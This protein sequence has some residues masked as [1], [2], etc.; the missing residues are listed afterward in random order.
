MLLSK[1]DDINTGGGAPALHIPGIQSLPLTCANNKVRKA[2]GS[3]K[4][5]AHSGLACK[6]LAMTCVKLCGSAGC[7]SKV[8]SSCG[9]TKFGEE[10]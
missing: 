7:V 2:A 10:R 8:R 9:G 5:S 3:Y 6:P 4:Y 1:V